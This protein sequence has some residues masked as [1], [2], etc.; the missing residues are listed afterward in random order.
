MTSFTGAGRQPAGGAH[1]P[2]LPPRGAPTRVAPAERVVG[3]EPRRLDL[4][5]PAPGHARRPLEDRERCLGP[6]P[7]PLG[8]VAV[9]GG[10]A[11]RQWGDAQAGDPDVDPAP[12]AEDKRE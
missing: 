7:H 11:A 2:A 9:H 8:F 5:I 3:G 6:V 4:A 10:G 12:A 1:A